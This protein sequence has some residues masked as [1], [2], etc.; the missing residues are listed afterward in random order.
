MQPPDLFSNMVLYTQDT[1]LSAILL[2]FLDSKYKATQV[3]RFTPPSRYSRGAGG[4]EVGRAGE[5][6]V[7]E[8]Q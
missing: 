4:M 2:Q 1:V 5:D 8:L 7:A 3:E 6:G